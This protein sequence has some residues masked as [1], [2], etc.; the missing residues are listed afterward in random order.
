MCLFAPLNNNFLIIRAFPLVT[1]KCKGV[2]PYFYNIKKTLK[3]IL[4]NIK[5]LH[6]LKYQF[7]FFSTTSN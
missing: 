1:A 6:H 4:F 5:K 2:N 7:I 3:A